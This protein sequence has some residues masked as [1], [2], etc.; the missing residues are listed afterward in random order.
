MNAT[1]LARRA[2]APARRRRA[3]FTL[4]EVVIAVVLLAAVLGSAVTLLDT[5][6]DLAQ[7]VNDERAAAMAR[8]NAVALV[9]SSGWG[10]PT[11]WTGV[12]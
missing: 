7:S 4:V 3:G 10:R 1:G 2:V 5:S 8:C 12:S 11:Q 9:T 6:S